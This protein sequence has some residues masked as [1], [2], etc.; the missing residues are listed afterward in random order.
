MDDEK[1]AMRGWVVLLYAV[2]AAASWFNLIFMHTHTLLV[3]GTAL[4]CSVGAIGTGRHWWWAH[5]QLKG[6]LGPQNDS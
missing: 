6:N 2:S 3:L 4:L 5:K 1:V